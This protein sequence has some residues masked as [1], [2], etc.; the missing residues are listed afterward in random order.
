[1]KI[2]AEFLNLIAPIAGIIILVVLVLFVCRE[3]KIKK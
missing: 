3:K 2:D 1:M